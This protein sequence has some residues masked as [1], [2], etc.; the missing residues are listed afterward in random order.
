MA[1]DNK[2]RYFKSC[3]IH[4]VSQAHEQSTSSVS[5]RGTRLTSAVRMTDS[6]WA[7]RA[8]EQDVTAKEVASSVSCPDATLR[9]QSAT[10]CREEG[11][12]ERDT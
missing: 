2:V 11:T 7:W 4:M 12:L 10:T 1:R 8:S 6:K 3:D 5:K 9:F